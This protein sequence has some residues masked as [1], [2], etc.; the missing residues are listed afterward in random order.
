VLILLSSA[1]AY[2]SPVPAG[3]I[4]RTPGRWPAGCCR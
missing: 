3:G 1:A 4:T 2:E